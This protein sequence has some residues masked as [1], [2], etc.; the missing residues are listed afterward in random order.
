MTDH[1]NRT[2]LLFDIEEFGKRDNVEQAYLRRLLY[3]VA[4]ATLRAAHVGETSRLRADRGDSVM[5]LID[6]Q[7]PVSGLLKTLLTETPALLHNKNRLMARSAQIRLRIVLASGYVAVDELDGWVGADLNHACRLLDAEPLR[8][9]LRRRDE[10]SVLCVSDALYQG[11]VRHGP[12]GVRPDAFHRV[13]VQAKEGPTVAWVH[14]GGGTDR[15]TP[16]AGT[17]RT[18]SEESRPATDPG[19]TPD[20]RPGTAQVGRDQYGVAGGT[21]H[22]DLRFD[23]RDRGDRR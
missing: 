21:V 14:G 20:T 15:T 4:D 22:G 11:V 23:F 7:V 19:P 16:E 18:T 6:A 13:T 2:I 10:D 3:D 1:V 8:D 9:A 12:V 17:G 5:E